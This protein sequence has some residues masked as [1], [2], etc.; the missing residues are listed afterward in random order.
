MVM[1]LLC[2]AAM[3]Q[4]A[5]AMGA[6][7]QTA[8]ICVEESIDRNVSD[9]AEM[10]AASI[11]RRIGITVNW[12]PAASLFCRTNSNAMIHMTY[13]LKTAAD[14]DPGALAS[15]TPYGAS[16]E[17]HYDRIPTNG[18]LAR[19]HVLAHVFVHEVAHILQGVARH[20][21]SG[22]MKARWSDSDFIEM[23][24]H[25]LNFTELDIA[26]IHSGLEARMNGALPGISELVARSSTINKPNDKS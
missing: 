25:P 26:L 15:A 11:F 16:V 4:G 7:R 9:H 23:K 17:V 13:S 24:W 10:E 8:T 19:A 1:A 6:P 20:S 18:E 5:P 3:T 21:D 2:A 14:V 12:H 22:M